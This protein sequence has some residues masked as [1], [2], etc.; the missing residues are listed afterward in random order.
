MAKAKKTAPKAKAKAADSYISDSYINDLVENLIA[1]GGEGSAQLLGSDGLAIKIKGVLSTQCPPVDAAIGRGGIPR[2]R[3]TILHGPEGSGKTTLALHLVAEAQRQDG[4]VL[5]IDKEY[6]LD[7]EY[8]RKIGVDTKRLLISQPPYLEKAYE[9]IATVVEFARRRRLESG[10][11][12]PIL[13]VLDSMNAAIA[14]ADY[15]G[16]WDDQSMAAAARVH[17]RLLPKLIPAVS[18]EDV[19]LL[20]ISQNREKLNVTWGDKNDT[21][22]GKAPK[23]YASL[24]MEIRRLGSVKQ[25][26]A[27]IGNEV[28]V[29]CRKNQIAPP[30]KRAKFRI[31]YGEGIDSCG[32]L[33]QRAEELGVVER[34]AS[35]YIFGGSRIGV[36]FE[37]TRKLLKKNPDL[38]ARLQAEVERVE[39]VDEVGDDDEE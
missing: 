21:A 3:L 1:V 32:A 30:F 25:G 27:I 14:K 29:Y 7:P 12:V 35:S 17:S 11:S 5:Y 31:Y 23:Y 24:I 13:V 9:T 37:A 38:V 28:E 6:K 19:S 26:D 20:F 15:E 34:K 36:G 2:G 22:G 18:R 10:V 4:V 8:A 33:L 39:R 16:D